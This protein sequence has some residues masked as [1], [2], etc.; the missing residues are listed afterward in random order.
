MNRPDIRIIS[1]GRRWVR[2]V[3]IVAV[4]IGG[5]LTH[6]AWFP[7]ARRG[8]RAVIAVF[9]PADPDSHHGSDAEHGDPH[10]GHDHAAHAGHHEDTSLELS[11]T[12]RRNI[13]LTDD[14]I[15]PVRLQTF[16]KTITVPAT[17]VEQAGRTRVQVATPMTGAI[18]HVHA[19]EGEAVQPGALLFRI[20]L[21]HEDLVKA[22]TSFVKTL[23]EL[24]VEENEIARLQEITSSGAV[25]GRLLLEREYSREKLAALLTAQQESLRLHGLS[26]SQV[27]Q[28]SETRR[29]LGE[30]QMYAPSPDDHSEDDMKLTGQPLQPAGFTV[31]QTPDSPSRPVAESSDPAAPLI[32]QDLRVHKGQ[33]VD[34]G[35]TLCVLTD[36][37]QLYIEGMAFESDISALRQVSRQGWNVSAVFGRTDD[38][39]DRVDDL[40]IAWLANEVDAESRSL[41]FYVEL[42]NQIVDDRRQP[43]GRFVDWKFSPGQRL[44]LQV[45]V[46][47]WPDRIVLPV[48]AVASE[49]A[50]YFVF[51]QN[52]DHFDRVAVHVE[53]RD[54]YSVVI[55]SDGALSPGDVVATTGAHQMQMAL[56]NQA[57]GGADPHAGHS[58]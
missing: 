50:E 36:L 23:G 9:R 30:L 13:G 40:E 31:E 48:D 17:I 56:R 8:V 11:D 37:R 43:N 33:S 39:S 6:S 27:A 55:A 41:R 44:Q 26:E 35:E 25:P 15:R 24:D 52:G 34:A 45:P 5:G 3:L 21:T 16:R 18:T 28:I 42:P 19:V 14:A 47:E 4:V 20:R 57:G 10:A 53:F 49:A 2:P 38:P 51:L 32:L 7:P 12:A 29:L 22:Q 58:H 54:Q 46:E 1:A